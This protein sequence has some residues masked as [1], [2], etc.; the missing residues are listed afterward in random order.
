[1]ATS[2]QL[3]IWPYSDGSMGFWNYEKGNV[4]DDPNSSGYNTSP[5]LNSGYIDIMAD[6]AYPLMNWQ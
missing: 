6:H 1:M 3:I 2:R 5:S 4:N